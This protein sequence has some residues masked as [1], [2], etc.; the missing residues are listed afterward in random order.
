VT[1]FGTTTAALRDAGRDVR[2]AWSHAAWLALLAVV[3]AAAIPFVPGV[4]RV[5]GLAATGYLA[6]AAIGLGFAAGI[7]GLPSLAQGA[8]VGV[9]AI[10]AAHLVSDGWPGPAAAVAGAAVAA[11]AGVAVGAAIVR[12]RPVYVAAVTWIVTWLFALGADAFPRLSGGTS[13]LTVTPDWSA[14]THYE[15]ALALVVLAALG[16]RA[17]SAGTFGLALRA[18]AQRP[19][20][21][22]ALGTEA[23]RLRLRAFAG[24]AAVGGLAGALDVQLAGVADA[25]AYGARLSFLLL[26]A[27][28]VGGAASAL[29]PVVGVLLLGALSLAAEAVGGLSGSEATRFAPLLAALLLVAVL[30]SGA[31]GIVP[32]VTARLRPRVR[33]GT[34]PA[35]PR[36][37]AGAVLEV[38]GAAKRFGGVQALDGLDLEVEPGR[39]VALVGPNGSGKTTALRVLAGTVR[40]DAGRVVLD[41]LDVTT[42][43]PA[44][45][46]RRGLVRTLQ[47]NGVFPELTALENA[48]VGA[49]LRG[50]HPGALRAL[51]AT[52]KARRD[53]EAVQGRALGA[54]R[55]V[56]LEDRRD[57]RAETLTTAEQR[58]LMV[59]SA[60]AAEPTVLLL[61][62]PSAGAGA[63]DLDRLAR[64]LGDLRARGLTVLV[65]EHNLGLVRAIAQEVVVLDAGRR[66][67]SGSPDDV[68]RNPAVREAYFGR[69]S[70][71][72][73]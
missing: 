29:G 45:R 8:F 72:P 64:I 39:V 27:V 24:A 48:I 40:A 47:S 54:L 16:H 42:E 71:E 6:L 41:G 34:P 50:R 53:A 13:G 59:A 55:A 17:L 63:A 9:G 38:R 21:A 1:P 56:G 68:A 23:G 66:L 18:A 61:D 37:V 46:A 22:A 4:P 73:S 33:P 32:A 58:L 30:T 35:S 2:T 52:P 7:G 69:R 51:L 26:V 3:V 44:G 11:A 43:P 60:L 36:P 28:L 5:D 19:A 25:S 15:L 70:A 10:A 14:T 31:D 12:F 65:V 67:A 62:E 49:S 20:A 57:E